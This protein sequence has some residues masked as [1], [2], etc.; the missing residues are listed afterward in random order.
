MVMYGNE[1]E[2]KENRIY[3]KDKIEPQHI[4]CFNLTTLEYLPMHKFISNT[5][6]YGFN[7]I[8][9]FQNRLTFLNRHKI[10]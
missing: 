3:T 10:I 7:M 6:R 5:L 9:A 2:T 8:K 1:I 4:R